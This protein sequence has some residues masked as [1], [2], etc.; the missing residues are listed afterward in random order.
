MITQKVWIYHLTCISVTDKFERW[1]FLRIC[2]T[3]Y[4]H[5]LLW[6]QWLHT[7]G[8]SW[9]HGG[10]SREE[11]HFVQ[12]DK[13]WAVEFK[14]GRESLEDDPHLEMPVTVTTQETIAK[15][16]DIIMAYR[17][18][19]EL[20]IATE[21]GIE[22]QSSTMN[23]KYRRWQL[24]GSQ[25]SLDPIRNGLGTYQGTMLPFLGGSQELSPAVHNHGWDLVPSL[26][27]RDKSQESQDGDVCR[28]GDGLLSSKMQECSWWST[29]K[30]SH[31]LW[32]LLH[33]SET[34]MGE[35]QEYLPWTVDARCALLPGQ[36]S[37][38]HVHSGHGAIHKCGFELSKCPHYSSVLASFD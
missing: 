2:L 15:I 9:G 11:Y 23:S 32:G 1:W 29:W 25:T 30:G 4:S 19:T 38:P 17:W 3:S 10:H 21:L 31:Y 16:H 34:A 12:H 20:N 7:W 33:W 36:C 35:N 6:S 8:G 5:Q 13:E 24:D 14:C 26:P 37:N 18:G 27:T 22:M 28:E